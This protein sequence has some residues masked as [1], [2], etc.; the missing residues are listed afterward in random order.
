KA[1]DGT[2][3]SNVG[4]VSL[5]VNPVNDLPTALPQTLSTLKNNALNFDLFGTDPENDS[6]SFVTIAGP[7]HG[8]LTTPYSWSPQRIYTPA[9]NYVGTDSFT[10]RANDGYGNGPLTTIT[11]NV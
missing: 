4:H 11:I 6:I 10:I 2:S 7:L 3:D 8:T 5:T 1:N 9:L